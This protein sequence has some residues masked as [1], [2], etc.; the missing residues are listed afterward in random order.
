V[1]YWGKVENQINETTER[2]RGLGEVVDCGKRSTRRSGGIA[3][4]ED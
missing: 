4:V 3:E 2:R 1:E